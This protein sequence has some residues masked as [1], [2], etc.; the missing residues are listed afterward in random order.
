MERVQKVKQEPWKKSN[1]YKLSRGGRTREWEETARGRKKTLVSQQPKR[2][3]FPHGERRQVSNAADT[4]VHQIWKWPD[5][6]NFSKTTTKAQPH[7]SKNLWN[8]TMAPPWKWLMSSA[9]L[10]AFNCSVSSSKV[11]VLIRTP[12]HFAADYCL[13]QRPS[14]W[15]DVLGSGGHSIRSSGTRA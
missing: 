5:K 14:Y 8:P 7:N 11:Q 2:S 10:S 3:M 15:L 1:T 13:G 9:S 12:S 4:R 6:G